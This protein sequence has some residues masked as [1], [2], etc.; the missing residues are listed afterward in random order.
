MSKTYD[1]M[2]TYIGTF[3]GDTSGAF[4]TLVG[5]DLNEVY[6]DI[7]RRI[8]W[9]ECIDDDYT[10]ESVADEA[11]VDLPDDFEKEVYITNIA[12][13]KRLK[14]LA[15]GE[16]WREKS[17]EFSSDAVDSGTTD[18]Y[19]ILEESGK[20]K[21]VPPPDKA[22]TY[23][24]P[25]KKQFTALSGDSD[26]ALIQGIDTLLEYGTLNRGFERK[27]LHSKAGYYLQKFEVGLARRISQ[28][29]SRGNYTYQMVPAKR[30]YGKKLR[31]LTG[32]TPYAV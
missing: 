30:W 15:I 31:Y 22:E 5:Q 25:Y 16:Y 8:E 28:E 27:Q 11:E 26:T 24:M 7:W 2:K 23:A 1:T 19:V 18:S 20:I 4:K 13:G 21:L 12:T 6:E 9:S 17:D 10:F 3:L 32:E 29:R 14:K